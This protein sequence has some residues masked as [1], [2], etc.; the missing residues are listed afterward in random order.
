MDTKVMAIVFAV[1]F[2]CLVTSSAESEG[3]YMERSTGG[4]RLQ[5]DGE[6]MTGS[7][8]ITVKLCFR[9]WCGAHWDVCYC[10]E[11]LPNM[12]CYP[13]QQKCW[14]VCPPQPGETIGHMYGGTRRFRPQPNQQV[15]LGITPASPSPG[16]DF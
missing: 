5:L 7:N 4:Y 14:D 13:E 6:E 8:K 3:N 15:H 10:C 9:K 1:F 12:P 2:V 16:N 11:T